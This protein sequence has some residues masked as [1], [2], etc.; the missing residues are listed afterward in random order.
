MEDFRTESLKFSHENEC[1]VKLQ[2]F[3]KNT[4]VDIKIIIRIEEKVTR[5]EKLWLILVYK[6]EFFYYLLGTV[7]F[8]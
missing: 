3:L 5:N 7:K 2:Y 4:I 8:I 6:Y 1:F